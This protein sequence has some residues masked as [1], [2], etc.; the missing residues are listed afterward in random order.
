MQKTRLSAKFVISWSSL[1]I[2]SGA[3]PVVIYRSVIHSPLLILVVL[4]LAYAAYH[5]AE[6]CWKIMMVIEKGEGKRP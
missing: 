5:S 1:I 3:I 6:Y 4:P 2:A